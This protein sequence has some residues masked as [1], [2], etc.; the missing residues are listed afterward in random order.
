MRVQVVTTVVT[1]QI[2]VVR[3][4]VA[5]AR[6]IDVVVLILAAATVAKIANAVNARSGAPSRNAVANQ[7]A[8][9]RI[10]SAVA[11]NVLNTNLTDVADVD[12]KKNRLSFYLCS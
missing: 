5:V 11:I 2:V 8:V 3:T 12:I 7:D 9:V 1:V 6:K 10:Q 4:V